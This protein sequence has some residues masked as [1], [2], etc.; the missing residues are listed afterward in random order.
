MHEHHLENL[1]RGLHLMNFHQMCEIFNLDGESSE[2]IQKWKEWLQ[3]DRA[4]RKF[5]Q[6]ELE[7]IA[8][9]FSELKQRDSQYDY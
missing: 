3:A 4:L 9:Y 8:E 5:Y 2:A 7:A 6:S 1:F